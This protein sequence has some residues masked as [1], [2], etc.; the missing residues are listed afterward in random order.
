MDITD[1]KPY[2]RNARHNEKAIPVVAESIKEFGFKGAT[3][4]RSRD[5][6]TI[7]NGHTR[8]AAC[9]LLAWTEFP[10]EYIRY[11]DDLTDEQ[12]RALRLADN[13]TDEVATWNKA[14][15]QHEVRAIK[16][17]DM[18]R[19]NFDFKGK[20]H[21]Y[22]AER[23]RG[24]RGYNLDL[25][26]AADCGTDGYSALAPADAR[27]EGLVGFNYAKST[28]EKDKRGQGRHFFVDDYQFERCWTSL[29]RFVQALRGFARPHAGLQP[30]HGHADADDGVEPLPER[31]ALGLY[32]QRE[33]MKVVPALSWAGPDSYAFCFE[34]VPKRSTVAV[35][36]V[37]VKRD[38]ATLDIWRDGMAEAMR[39]LAPSRVL[40]YGGDVGFDFGGCEVVEYANG[41]TERM[42]R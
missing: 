11:A 21:P 14:L 33:G 13:R 38:A 4:L 27:P 18:G 22:G 17:L 40:L 30:V 10:D 6:P 23:L 5:D 19:S 2:P 28:Q 39:R 37:G 9:K 12:V 3:V 26:P 41:I 34:G 25:V 36:T 15:L 16:S 35:S 8:V 29:I 31:K 32:W 24:D 1:I 42:G 7:V 20:A